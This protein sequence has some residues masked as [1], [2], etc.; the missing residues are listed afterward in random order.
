MSAFDQIPFA[1]TQDRAV[2]LVPVEIASIS[3]VVALANRSV[4]STRCF[5]K[6]SPNSLGLRRHNAKSK[7]SVVQPLE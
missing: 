3:A 5:G 6:S 7:G 1:A 2:R 4:N